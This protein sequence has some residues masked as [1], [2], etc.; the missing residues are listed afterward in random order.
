MQAHTRALRHVGIY[1]FRRAALFRFLEMDRTPLETAEGLEQLRAL[2]NGMR[3]MVGEIAGAPVGVD[4][5]AD[6]ELVRRLWEQQ[7]DS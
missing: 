3:I 7:S 2:E 6:L 5:P 4:T 1:A